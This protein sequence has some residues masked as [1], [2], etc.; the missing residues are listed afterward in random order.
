LR[1]YECLVLARL[2]FAQGR[3]Q[4]VLDILA[5]VLPVAEHRRRGLIEIEVHV[6]RA[7]T[8]Q[9]LGD[10]DMAVTA[11]GSALSLAEPHGHVRVFLDEGESMLRLLYEAVSRGVCTEYAARLLAAPSALD[12]SPVLSASL[13]LEPLAE[14]LSEREVEVLRL[15]ASGLSNREIGRRLV[16]SLNTV[17]GHTRAIYAKLGVHSRTQA[18]AKARQLNILPPA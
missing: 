8:Y 4:E 14:P 16:L 2:L 11:L 13:S 6:L 18:V 3:Y 12:P 5:S 9:T 17:K 15:V 10:D 7:L 1:K